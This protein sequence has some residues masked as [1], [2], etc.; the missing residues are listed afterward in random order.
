MEKEKHSFIV[1]S[2]VKRRERVDKNVSQFYY[3]IVSVTLCWYSYQRVLYSVNNV[4]ALCLL[5]AK[6]ASC[7]FLSM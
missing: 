5:A 4:A 1:Q 2:P 3:C 6:R 7:L